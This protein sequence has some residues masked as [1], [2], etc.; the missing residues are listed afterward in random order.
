MVRIAA[1]VLALALL[2]ARP[3]RALAPVASGAGDLFLLESSVRLSGA[4]G[5]LSADVLG[6]L[7]AFTSPASTYALGPPIVAASYVRGL[8]DTTYGFAG[9]SMRSASGLS[10]CLGLAYART[11]DV[12]IVLPGEPPR[13]GVPV[14]DFA[15]ALTLA[16]RRTDFV[17][18]GL[19]LKGFDSRLADRHVR[20]GAL[21]ADVLLTPASVAPLRIQLS[22]RDA[23]W[24]TAEASDGQWT[25]AAFA[26]S[27]CLPVE[28]AV[29]QRLT[30]G[31]QLL[32]PT[33]ATQPF[34]VAAGLEY[35]LQQ[36][37]SFRA[38][39]RTGALLSHATLG[40]GL[41][42]ANGSLDYA[43]VPF[44][45]LGISHRLAVTFAMK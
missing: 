4:A 37:V 40:L 23:G 27:L 11:D 2:V 36:G 32:R 30:M 1:A 14:Y 8:L 35:A 39:Y 16:K 10:T 15:F 42:L 17:L 29:G 20:G 31:A 21:D 3:A 43:F 25:A 5:A 33:D 7:G 9:A 18:V 28:V 38:G 19:G 44:A 12:R 22:L 26:V 13:D 24:A 41:H 6:P 45:E 34:D